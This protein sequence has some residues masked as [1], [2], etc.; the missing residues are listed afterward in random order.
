MGQDSL[1]FTRRIIGFALWW[2]A[3]VPILSNGN[4]QLPAIVSAATLLFWIASTSMNRPIIY[5]STGVCYMAGLI[6]MLVLTSSEW[7][8]SGTCWGFLLSSGLI[9]IVLFRRLETLRPDPDSI[10][11]T[12]PL[13]SSSAPY[14]FPVLRFILFYLIW[15]AG[16]IVIACTS[17]SW[18]TTAMIAWTCAMFITGYQIIWP[19]AAYPEWLGYKMRRRLFVSK[20]HW[21]VRFLITGLLIAFCIALC[22]IFGIQ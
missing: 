10:A 7:L 4:F 11:L 19:F 1:R 12:S 14:P 17:G 22:I 13:P 8:F 3:S 20:K 16:F 6:T 15:I 18:Q 9:A 21:C 5:R 2:L